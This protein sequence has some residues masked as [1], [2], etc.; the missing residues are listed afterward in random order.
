MFVLFMLL[1]TDKS[2][3]PKDIAA[4]RQRLYSSSI[5]NNTRTVK[6]NKSES[7]QLKQVQVS[8][9]SK[10]SKN[11]S[12]LVKQVQVEAEDNQNK[13]ESGIKNFHQWGQEL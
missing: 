11:K 1:L 8:C 5:V 13:P 6:W 9:P 4:A 10:W 2:R 7:S 12:S 3:S